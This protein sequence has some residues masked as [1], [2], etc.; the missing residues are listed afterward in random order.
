MTGWPSVPSI[1]E[2]DTWPWLADLRRQLGAAVDAGRRA[3]RGL[4]RAGAARHRRG[5]ADGGLGTQPGRAGHRP[6]ERRA[7]GRVPRALPDL[8]PEDVVGS[9]Y[10]VRRYVVDAAPRRPG[11]AGRGPRPSWP[12]AGCA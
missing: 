1:Y 11:R 9:P 4:G 3:R 6:A 10:C 5:V 8:T 12:G 7:A 2:V